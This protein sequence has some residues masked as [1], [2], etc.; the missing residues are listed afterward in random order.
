MVGKMVSDDS[1]RNEMRSD[2]SL[3]WCDVRSRSMAVNSEKN[4]IEMESQW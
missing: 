3:L 1:G 4:K 2:H